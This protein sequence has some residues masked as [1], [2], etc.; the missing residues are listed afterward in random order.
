MLTRSS[1]L[2]P[3]HADGAGGHTSAPTCCCAGSHCCS[4]AS[5]RTPPA[6]PGATSA[7][8]CTSSPRSNLAAPPDVSSRPPNPPAVT[9]AS[10]NVRAQD[11]APVPGHHPQLNPTRTPHGLGT[12]RVDGPR[13]RNRPLH[14]PARPH[15][16]L[17]RAYP[18]YLN[19]RTPASGQGRGQT[20]GRAML[21]ELARDV[22]D[23]EF[24]FRQ[25][26]ANSRPCVR[27]TP[28]SSRLGRGK[29]QPMATHST[30]C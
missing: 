20:I 22:V 7:V 18:P 5:P 23:S 17:P 19:C 15:T 4:P 29:R 6:T 28:T 9:P 3:R 1:S 30:T 16:P 26:A 21:P 11:P 10:T 12:T 2:A 24:T 8:T 25:G 27:A 13:R 14:A